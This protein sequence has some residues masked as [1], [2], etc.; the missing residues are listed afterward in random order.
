MDL[1]DHYRKTLLE[2]LHAK[3]KHMRPRGSLNLHR[4]ALFCFAGCE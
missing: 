1:L 4:L 2:I 3:P